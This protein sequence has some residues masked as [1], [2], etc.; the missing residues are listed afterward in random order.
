MKFNPILLVPFE[1]GSG[2][3]EG[4]VGLEQ[5]SGEGGETIYA[6]EIGVEGEIELAV[7]IKAGNGSAV[8]LRRILCGADHAFCPI[9]KR[10]I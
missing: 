9:A 2:G 7:T 3:L 10:R 4:P 6:I 8:D 1:G 5:G